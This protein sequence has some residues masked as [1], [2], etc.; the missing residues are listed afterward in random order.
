MRPTRRC[1][2]PA[3]VVVPVPVRARFLD[4]HADLPVPARQAHRRLQFRPVVVRQDR[5]LAHHPTGPTVRDQVRD[6]ACPQ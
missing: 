2:D 5:R 6:D 1:H 3:E 4:R